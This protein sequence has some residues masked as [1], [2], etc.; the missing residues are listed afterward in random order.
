MAAVLEI[1]AFGEAIGADEDVELVVWWEV[2]FVVG[3]G[4]EAAD[5]FLRGG[6]AEA[7]CASGAAGDE[8][9]AGVGIFVGADCAVDRVGG[10]LVAGEN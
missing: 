2:G 9:D 1:D 5:D 6:F 10:V 7:G 4:C 8:A 3:D